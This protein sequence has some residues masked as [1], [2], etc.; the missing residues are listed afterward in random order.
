[1]TDKKTSDEYKA[2]LQQ[3]QLKEIPE[4]RGSETVE[5]PC[6]LHNTIDDTCW[7]LY[8]SLFFSKKIWSRSSSFRPSK[9][10]LLF[11]KFG[12][13]QHWN[14]SLYKI[15]LFSETKRKCEICATMAKMFRDDL[16]DVLW[17][18]LQTCR[19]AELCQRH[20]SCKLRRILSN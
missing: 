20:N 18:C 1:M 14:G 19:W 6:I 4:A 15:T 16:L 12:I 2:D 17:P 10:C 7:N 5:R 13:W 8:R 3:H 9:K 11:M